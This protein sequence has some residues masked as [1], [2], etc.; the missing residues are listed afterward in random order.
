MLPLNHY[1]KGAVFQWV[2]DSMCGIQ[3]EDENH[4]RV[5]PSPGGHFT[6]AKAAYA[7][8]YGKIESGWMRKDNA[9]T[10]TITVPANCTAEVCLPD[11]SYR[12][13]AAGTPSYTMLERK[14]S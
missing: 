13:Q 10:F 7:S 6:Y 2:F 1:S 5:V 8:V 14:Q 12:T 11:G 9:I 4:F 3:V